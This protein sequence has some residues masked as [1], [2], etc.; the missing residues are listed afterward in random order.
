MIAPNSADI[1]DTI[2]N[3]K[4]HPNSAAA[5]EKIK[6]IYCFVSI[7]LC[8][9]DDVVD[10]N[11]NKFHEENLNLDHNNAHTLNSVIFEFINFSN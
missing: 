11:N 10:D 1:I 3:V 2:I 7:M 4:A 8:G 9:Y 6:F 5:S